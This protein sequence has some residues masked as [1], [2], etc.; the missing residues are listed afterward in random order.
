MKKILS[1]I[2][3]IFFISCKKDSVDY[4]NN[5]F[6]D[7]RDGNI[8]KIVTIGNQVWMAENLRYLP[9]V[10]GNLDFQTLGNNSQPAYGVYGYERG[11]RS[12]N[13]VTTA[14]AEENY[15]TYGVL[16]N[17]WAAMDGATSS[18]SN[19]SKIQ[20]VCP[21]GW[22]LPSDS[23]WKD[24]EMELGMSEA[25]IENY[26]GSELLFELRG[27]N[28]GSKL[29]GNAFLWRDGALKNNA[30]FSSIGFNA[31]P[32]GSHNIFDF[33]NIG[34]YGFW[35]SA[36]DDDFLDGWSRGLHYNYSKVFRLLQ[37]KPNGFSVRCVKD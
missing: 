18:I 4:F 34:N 15:R 21:D 20:G 26:K 29:A 35:W 32:G 30:E 16:Y 9:K 13:D 1:V 25:D 23:E 14:K 31:L 8:Y 5:S 11:N 27:N 7:N 37:Y 12:P 19:P 10:H 6:L 36:T 24:L 22:H 3:I 2:L 33:K 17:W 28:E